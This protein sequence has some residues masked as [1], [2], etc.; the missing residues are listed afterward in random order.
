[1]DRN[2][3]HPTLFNGNQDDFVVS[4]NENERLN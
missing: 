3:V 4:G 1:M 2:K